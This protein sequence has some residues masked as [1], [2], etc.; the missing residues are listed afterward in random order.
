MPL[1]QHNVSKNRDNSCVPC[2]YS[3][4]NKHIHYLLFTQTNISGV[5]MKATPLPGS[6]YINASFVDVRVC[7]L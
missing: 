6:D 7:F 2:K 4:T 5:Q 3:G 1:S